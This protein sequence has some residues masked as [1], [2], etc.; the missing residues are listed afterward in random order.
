VKAADHETGQPSQHPF[1]AVTTPDIE[2]RP[3]VRDPFDSLD[4]LMAF[5]ETL[6]PVWP[7]R[8]P[9]SGRG[10]FKL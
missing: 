2:P 7:Q 4:H 8:E 10:E 1:A 3:G 6:C 9:F 5:I